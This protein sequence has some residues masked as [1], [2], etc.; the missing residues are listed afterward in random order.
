MYIIKRLILPIIFG[1]IAAIL[2]LSGVVWLLGYLSQLTTVQTSVNSLSTNYN[3]FDFLRNI[4]SIITYII[5]VVNIF[6]VISFFYLQHQSKKSETKVSNMLYWYNNLIVNKNLDNIE[7][8]FLQSCNI[9]NN[10]NNIGEDIKKNDYNKA[11]KQQFLLFTNAKIKLQHVFVDLIRVMNNDL[12][13]AIDD[14]LAELQDDLTKALSQ[15]E[16]DIDYCE[17]IVYK[18]RQK[19]YQEVYNHEQACCQAF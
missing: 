8:F 11:I 6:L 17:T 16:I 9:I 5:A 10:I 13:Q 19:I 1:I 14:L 7:N 2:M 15:T 4:S 18:Y 3:F 12:G